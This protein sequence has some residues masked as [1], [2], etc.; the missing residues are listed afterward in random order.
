M[1]T[2]T[3]IF[4]DSTNVGH[5]AACRGRGRACVACGRHRCRSGD[6]R[7]WRIFYPGAPR[8]SGNAEGVRRAGYWVARLSG[9]RRS[10]IARPTPLPATSPSR[11]WPTWSQG[12]VDLAKVTSEDP[13]AGLPEPAAMGQIERRTRSLLRRRLW[14]A[15]GAADW[16]RPARWGRGT[17]GRP[18]AQKERRRQLRRRHRAQ[19]DGQFARLCGRVSP[20]LL[21]PLHHADRRDGAGRH[22]AGLLVFKRAYTGAARFSGEYRSRGGPA[23]TAPPECTPGANTARAHC[24]CSGDCAFAYR[25]HLWSC[26]WWQHVSRRLLLGQ[27]ARAAGGECKCNRDW[28]RH[29]A[30]ALRHLT[31]RRRRAAHAAH[32]HRGKWR[33]QELPAEYLYGTQAQNGEHRQCFPRAGRHSWDR[34]RQPFSAERYNYSPAAAR[35]RKSW[36]LCHGADGIR[37]EHG[38]RRLLPRCGWFVDRERRADVRGGGDDD[39]RQSERDAQQHHRHRRRPGISG[40][41]LPH[42]PYASTEW[43]S[44]GNRRQNRKRNRRDYSKGNPGSYEIRSC[45][46]HPASI[47]PTLAQAWAVSRKHRLFLLFARLILAAEPY[48]GKTPNLRRRLQ[49]FLRGASGQ[50]GRSEWA[51]ESP[52]ATGAHGRPHRVQ[53]YRLRLRIFLLPLCSFLARV[54]W[55]GTATVASSPPVVSAYVARKLRI[56]AFTYHQGSAKSAANALFGPFPSRAAAERYADEMLNLFLLRRCTEDLNPDPAFPGC[57]YSEMKMCLAPCYKGCSD[58]R[59]RQ[60]SADVFAF[61]STRGASMLARLGG[62]RTLPRK[63]WSSSAPRPSTSGCRRFKVWLSLASE[64]VHPLANWPASWCSHRQSPTMW[65]SFPCG[66]G[67]WSGPASVFHHR[68]AAGE[69][70]I[71]IEF[72][73]RSSFCRGARSPGGFPWS[74]SKGSAGVSTRGGVVGTGAVCTENHIFANTVGS[75]GALHTMVLPTCGALHGRNGLRRSRWADGPQAIAARHFPS[76][77]ARQERKPGGA[78]QAPDSMARLA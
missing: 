29:H 64:A 37:R 47:R 63:R 21:L 52:P 70:A 50:R 55:T 23:H 53:C 54:R 74:E 9:P 7:R 57:V 33:S 28:R 32:R 18:A 15:Y 76:R 66:A 68:Y 14:S 36:L 42:P 26:Q 58:E 3:P 71:R 40:S 39:C 6:S 43:R 13:F 5:A 30:G 41:R 4:D 44:P 60:E 31:L 12:A 45:S 27:P 48:L 72:P 49:R 16:I 22:A 38:D 78:E 51:P 59:Y 56:L 69:W 77:R 67:Y 73:L 46:F 11:A 20:L 34:R 25:Q 10:L 62:E 19:S 35:R 61:L 75:L 2:A 8:P 1:S 24:L 65:R 17:I